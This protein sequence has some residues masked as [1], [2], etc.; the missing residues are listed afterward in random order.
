MITAITTLFT[1]LTSGAG[2]G[3]LGGI[4]GL[5]KQSQEAKERIE[6]EKIQVERDRIEI[7]DRREEREHQ[8]TMLER[9]AKIELDKVATESQMAME[10]SNQQALSAAQV[11]EFS[12][13]NTTR[14]MDNYRASVRPTLAYWVAVIFTIALCWA[15]YT[16]REQLSPEDGKAIL[17]GL[18]GT[19]TFALTSVIT[20]YYVSRRNSKPQ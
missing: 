14:K 9:G 1:V 4:F 3:L 18:F 5:F 7:E 16:Y 11:A 2:G 19:L 8:L 12:G 6:M 20:F 17:M 13:L 15:F 10:I